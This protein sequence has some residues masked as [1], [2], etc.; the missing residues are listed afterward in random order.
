M[1]LRLRIIPRLSAW[2]FQVSNLRLADTV[3]LILLASM[4]SPKTSSPFR[5]MDWYT[6]YSVCHAERVLAS[7]SDLGEE[8]GR[9]WKPLIV[10]HDRPFLMWIVWAMRNHASA[11]LEYQ[12]LVG[13]QKK[14]VH[15]G[16]FSWIRRK[17]SLPSSHLG[18]VSHHGRRA[19]CT[20]AR[21]SRKGSTLVR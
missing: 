7:Q 9:F 3:S 20:V 21:G 19:R 17:S 5:D 13:A 14:G 18:I 12:L 11:V 16:T 15:G 4:R 6:S 1:A 8:R 10:S 2:A